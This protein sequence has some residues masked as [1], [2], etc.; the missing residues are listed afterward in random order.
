M[1]KKP[2]FQEKSASLQMS[3]KG[4][5]LS[6]GKKENTKAYFVNGIRILYKH[7]DYGYFKAVKQNFISRF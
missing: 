3:R 6:K 4:K 2:G 1:I 5:I 7:S